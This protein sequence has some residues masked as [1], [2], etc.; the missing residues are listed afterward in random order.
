M[1]TEKVLAQHHKVDLALPDYEGT[2]HDTVA[3]LNVNATVIVLLIAALVRDIF[4]TLFNQSGETI[5]LLGEPQCDRPIIKLLID[6]MANRN[7]GDNC[8]G[9][10]IW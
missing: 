1:G 10:T 2:I 3:A 7:Q 8:G 6:V 5:M 9:S 4:P